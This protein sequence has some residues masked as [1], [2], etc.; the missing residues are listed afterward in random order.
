MGENNTSTLVPTPGPTD[1]AGV[2]K[3]RPL[4]PKDAATLVVVDESAPQPR[5]LMGRRRADLAFMPNK[6]VFP[7]G[8][9]DKADRT[10]LSA[11]ELA[12]R[13]IAKLLKD[14]KGP[15]SI[16]RARAIALAALREAFEEAGLVVG[17]T[18]SGMARPKAPTSGV[19]AD[20]FATGAVPSLAPLSLLARAITPPGRLRRYDTRFF[21][22]PASAVTM[23]V[24]K[25]DDELSAIDWFTFDEIRAL[26]VPAITRA[27][28]EDLAAR[29]AL[30]PAAADR[31]HVPFY[32]FQ[33]GT[34]RRVLL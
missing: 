23:T 4:R 27:I 24:S 17:T 16:A 13:E 1:G 29:L 28:V 3:G 30:A 32:Y 19:W 11:D 7:G 15:V 14:M 34:F 5:V 21:L 33:G 25:I 8:R 12:E 10:T 31:P 6:F 22:A 20:F 18:A 26:D 2:A 9:V